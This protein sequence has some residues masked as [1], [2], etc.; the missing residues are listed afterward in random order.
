MV[1]PR[2]CRKK[3]LL[4]GSTPIQVGSDRT[5]LKI[6]TSISAWQ[7]AFTE[8]GYDVEWRPVLAGEDVSHYDRVVVSLN[9]PN[10]IASRHVNGAL[11]CLAQ[12]P[13][14]IVVLDD[15]QNFE[16]V[17]DLRS[18]SMLASRMF[19]LRG[20]ELSSSVQ[21]TV[22][23][24]AKQLATS[25]WRHRVV[26]PILGDGDTS[27]LNIPAT[28]TGLDPTAFSKRYR[29]TGGLSRVRQWIQASLL[30]KPLAVGGWPV[31]GYGWKNSQ[32]G[33]GGTGSSAQPRL[34]EPELMKVY[35]GAWGVLSPAHPHAGS[36]WWRVRYLMAADAG[37]ILS[38]CEAE[39]ACLGEPYVKTAGD[40]GRAL[41]ERSTDGRLRRLARDQRV[42]LAEV[43]WPKARVLDS[44]SSVLASAAAGR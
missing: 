26:A 18:C 7:S 36:G 10:S 43:T 22:L 34:T 44:L 6:I 28:V 15:W 20:G 21:T 4:T 24:Y 35:E 17:A 37:C 31:I 3:L 23:N 1:K 2:I 11:W 42:R 5:Q 33:L 8:L 41:V 32:R 19:R 9:K 25:R 16:L 40:A 39:A 12:R 14:A 30:H 29:P 13:D 38:A 27:K